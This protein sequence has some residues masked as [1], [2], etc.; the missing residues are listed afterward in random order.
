MEM[1][2]LPLRAL[3]LLL[4]AAVAHGQSGFKGFPKAGEVKWVVKNNVTLDVVLSPADGKE[5]KG[6]FTVELLPRW[7]PL[8]VDRF[9]ALVDAGYFTGSRFYHVFNSAK[10]A[11]YAQFGLSAQASSSTLRMDLST[12]PLGVF[13]AARFF[14][15]CHS[16]NDHSHTCHTPHMPHAT[17]ATA[18]LPPLT[19]TELLFTRPFLHSKQCA[20]SALS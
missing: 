6:S 20:A 8:A 5:R 9:K 18:H 16:H 2:L 19:H 4:G 7:A 13:S 1:A 10:G 12:A 14:A 3:L 15:Q 11:S 17:H